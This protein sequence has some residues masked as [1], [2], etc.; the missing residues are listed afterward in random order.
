[1]AMVRNRRKIS[2]D[3]SWKSYYKNVQFERENIWKMG[4]HIS[5]KCRDT[6]GLEIACL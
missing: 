1:M 6:R 2:D 3:G 4:I 5:F